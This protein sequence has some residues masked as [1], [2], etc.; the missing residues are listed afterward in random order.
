MRVPKY[1]IT[2]EKTLFTGRFLDFFTFGQETVN[3]SSL[4]LYSSREFWLSSSRTSSRKTETSSFFFP[5][6]TRPAKSLPGSCQY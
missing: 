3:E 6:S 2:L 5:A 1:K 4:S